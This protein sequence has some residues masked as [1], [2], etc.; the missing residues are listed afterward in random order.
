[1]ILALE[2]REWSECEARR[3]RQGIKLARDA[4]GPYAYDARSR[5]GMLQKVACGWDSTAHL[6]SGGSLF[7]QV[8]EAVFSGGTPH[9]RA[10][11]LRGRMDAPGRL[12]DRPESTK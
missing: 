11:G 7:V 9:P 6:R 12:P 5:E 3:S 10:P 4:V 1:M 2:F 8:S